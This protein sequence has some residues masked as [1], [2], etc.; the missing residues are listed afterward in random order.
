VV[1]EL[2][3]LG[4][5]GVTQLQTSMALDFD[6]GAHVHIDSLPVL[7]HE[8]QN[9]FQPGISLSADGTY[10]QDTLP[11]FCF[12]FNDVDDYHTLLS[13]SLSPLGSG[14]SLGLDQR[15][16]SDF[17]SPASL[18]TWATQSPQSLASHTTDNVPGG[19]REINPVWTTFVCDTC[20]ATF[21]SEAR[22][23][24]HKRQSN[25]T[26][27]P[28][29]FACSACSRL[30]SCAKNLKRHQVSACALKARL[31][32]PRCTCNK[33]FGRKDVLQRHMTIA[34]A[35]SLNQQHKCTV[36]QKPRCCC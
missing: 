18:A 13:S 28:P 31:E 9:P 33:S 35:R 8:S 23:M 6:F 25:C 30:F 21:T 12:N 1:A 10:A 3:S 20:K 16:S 29:N 24:K 4:T 22:Y 11:Q 14:D 5:V 32:K 26:A 17:S 27:P 2:Q 7:S 19:K 36:C 34:N 15:P